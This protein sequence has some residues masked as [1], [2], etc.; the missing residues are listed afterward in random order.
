MQLKLGLVDV[1]VIMMVIGLLAGLLMPGS[2]FDLKHRFP[3]TASHPSE[4]IPS[5]AGDYYYGDGR[6]TNLRLSIIPDGRYSLIRSGCTGVYY[7]ESGYVRSA[8]GSYELSPLGRAESQVERR[9]F[10][11]RWQSRRYLVP[12]AKMEV[13]CEAIM[14]GDEPRYEATGHFYLAGQFE[15]ALFADPVVG[16]PELPQRWASYVRERVAIGRITDLEEPGVQRVSLGTTHGIREG[17]ILTVRDGRRS[18]HRRLRVLSAKDDS[19]AAEECSPDRNDE[20]LEPG[21]EVIA[22]QVVEENEIP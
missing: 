11:V 14:K 1:C 15:R 9:L 5:I 6:G 19:C 16:L 21:Q 22:E 3:P 13:F 4:D 17:S 2:D 7:R 18:Y 20:P 10:L 12:S 8:D